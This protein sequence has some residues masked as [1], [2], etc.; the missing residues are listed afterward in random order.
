LCFFALVWFG[1]V[2]YFEEGSRFFDKPSRFLLAAFVF[3]LLLKSQPKAEWFWAGIIIGAISAGLVGVYDRFYLDQERATGFL[4]P[5]QFGNQSLL[6]GLIALTGLHWAA[7]KPHTKIWTGLLLLAFLM[8]LAGSL[9]S[10]TRGGWILLPLALLFIA[11]TYRNL[12]TPKKLIA[13]FSLLALGVAAAYQTPQTHIK[14]RIDAAVQEFNLYVE[15]G[16]ATGSVGTRLEMWKHALHAIGEAPLTGYGIE[17]Y[18][19]KIQQDIQA[20]G[21]A[22]SIRPYGHPHNEFLDVT[23]KRGLLGL[24]SLLLLY[25]M[26]WLIF[27]ARLKN[28]TGINSFAL[29][30]QI[31]II[32]HVD[33]G[34]S[35]AYLMHNNGV[36]V[37]AFLT[38]ILAAM[39]LKQS[40]K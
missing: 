33:F 27:T 37:L 38:V 21:F 15:T 20:H 30:G 16:E 18:K 35:Q 28:P 36:T 7:H 17:G 39:S 34:F 32:C 14:D 8:G 19:E 4:N 24:A 1:Q 22:E 10:G 9:L 12:I 23:V 31:T 5:I 40:P 26:L 2:I 13:S 11:L 6:F 3:L 25:G 29:A